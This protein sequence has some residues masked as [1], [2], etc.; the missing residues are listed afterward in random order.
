MAHTRKR[1]SKEKSLIASNEWKKSKP[2]DSSLTVYSVS[3]GG[4]GPYEDHLCKVK[5]ETINNG[6]YK[7]SGETKIDSSLTNGNCIVAES[8]T[9]GNETLEDDKSTVFK[10]AIDN[11][12]GNKTL[13]DDKSTVFKKAIDNYFGNKTLEDDKSTVFKKAIDNSKEN[14]V[15]TDLLT[16]RNSILSQS[17]LNSTTVKE[18]E[19]VPEEK[20]EKSQ[21]TILSQTKQSKS[22]TCVCGKSYSRNSNL[23]RH[24]KAHIGHEKTSSSRDGGP[25]KMKT[26]IEKSFPCIC[27]KSFTI[28]SHLNRHLKT[29]QVGTE[30]KI[31]P[32]ADV[33]PLKDYV[34]AC[35]KRYTCSSH[36]YRH[37][38]SHVDGNKESASPYLCHCGKMFSCRSHLNRHQRI[39]AKKEQIEEHGG[40]SVEDTETEVPGGIK[41]YV[42]HCG[43]SY[44][45]SSHLYRHQRTHQDGNVPASTRNRA[46]ESKIEKPYKCACGKSYTCTS[47]LY[48][49]QRTTHKAQELIVDNLE[50][51]SDVQDEEPYVKPYQCE[52][53]KSFIL[54]FSLMV[55]KKIHC[56]VKLQ[57][58]SAS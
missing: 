23:N 12:F 16:D 52:C 42:C 47:H 35:G 53:G 4:S 11:Y 13:E 55:H 54:L 50:Y 45:S 29:C 22:Y 34:C 9:F 3:S 24:L 58:S 48:R 14:L 19:N 46:G 10:K 40:D 1:A 36:L 17:V 8:S 33:S 39:H 44:T 28:S 26:P 18:E 30:T 7:R 37:Q 21:S 20:S 27:G 38:K 6:E 2:S 32:G 15:E 31:E 57:S 56:K 43:K 41:P 51:D 49:H 5:Q 25:S